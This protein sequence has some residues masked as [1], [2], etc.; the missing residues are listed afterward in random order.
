MRRPF[1]VFSFIF[2]TR[3]RNSWIHEEWIFLLSPWKFIFF[4]YSKNDVT[5]NNSIKWHAATFCVPSHDVIFSTVVVDISDRNATLMK[6][7]HSRAARDIRWQMTNTNL[8]LNNEV[9]VLN[10]RLSATHNALYRAFLH[11][12]CDISSIFLPRFGPT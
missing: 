7:H 8:Y 12:K 5:I 10:D 3:P 11:L 4:Y 2:H 1:K 6:L 9:K